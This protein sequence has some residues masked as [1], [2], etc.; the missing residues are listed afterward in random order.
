MCKMNRQQAIN[1][2]III[3]FLINNRLVDYENKHIIT[4]V[5]IYILRIK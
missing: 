5:Y 1:L 2:S 3:A 4:N